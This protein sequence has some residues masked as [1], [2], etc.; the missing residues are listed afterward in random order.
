MSSDLQHKMY[1][2]QPQPPAGCWDKVVSALDEE[3]SSLVERFKQYQVQPPVEVWNKIVEGLNEQPKKVVPLWRRGVIKYIAAACIIGLIVVSATLLLNKN[4]NQNPIS[5][6]NQGKQTDQPSNSLPEQPIT[7]NTDDITKI[8]ASQTY[9][10]AIAYSISKPKQIERSGF[11]KT[12]GTDLPAKLTAVSR[13]DF[14]ATVDRYM[15]YS[16]GKGKAMRLPKKIFDSISC[17]EEEITC[18][19]RIQNLQQKIANAALTSDFTAVLELLNNVREN[20]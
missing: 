18:K 3:D 13:V 7:N 10:K 9:N 11:I 6:T 4:S 16:D 17:V 1:N 19:Q 14:A 15:V 20:Q 2:Y 5:Q 8:N 12:P